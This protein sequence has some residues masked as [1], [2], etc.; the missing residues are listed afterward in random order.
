VVQTGGSRLGTSGHMVDGAE[1]NTQTIAWSSLFDE[2]N[3]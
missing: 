2:M 1:P 3:G